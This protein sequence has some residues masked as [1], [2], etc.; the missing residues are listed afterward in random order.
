M[1]DI[2][3]TPEELRNRA[4]TFKYAS[5]EATDRHNRILSEVF[6]LQMRWI[7][8]SSL[9]FYNDLPRFNKSY[10]EYV[11]CLNHIESELE[12]IAEKFEQADNHYI[13]KDAGAVI[14]DSIKDNSPFAQVLNY[15]TD[16]TLPKNAKT[17]FDDVNGYDKIGGEAKGAVIDAGFKVGDFTIHEQLLRGEVKAQ[18]GGGIG[19]EAKAGVT[20]N[21]FGVDHED[22]KVHVKVGNAEAGVEAKDGHVGIGAKADLIKGE[23]E[24][25]IP[26]PFIDD[27]KIVVGGEAAYGSIGGEAKLGLMNELDVGFGI[28]LGV[29]FGV[30]KD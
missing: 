13:F 24:V 1:G 19:G 9:T 26:I 6:N 28:G 14:G 2:K 25:K 11:Q 3:V 29:K 4:K 27:W 8:A 5:A 20:F 17:F 16:I 21:D 12:R 22:G 18:F 10:E 23:A 15:N 7:G 30:E